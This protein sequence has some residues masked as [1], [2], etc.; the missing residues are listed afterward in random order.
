M[1]QQGVIS[2]DEKTLSSRGRIGE[3]RPVTIGIQPIYD[4]LNK[5]GEVVSVGKISE[6]LKVHDNL[7]RDLLKQAVKID[8]ARQEEAG[9]II[10]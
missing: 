10:I 4:W 7:D 2:A 1:K 8:G 9:S 6:Y 5:N 3:G